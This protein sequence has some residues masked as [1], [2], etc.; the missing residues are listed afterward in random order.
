[1]FSKQNP[2]RKSIT[3]YAQM[4]ETDKLTLRYNMEAVGYWKK[5]P[6]GLSS[7]TIIIAMRSLTL[8]GSKHCQCLNSRPDS[9]LVQGHV[10][11]VVGL[12]ILSQGKTVFVLARVF[13]CRQKTR[14]SSLDWHH[15]QDLPGLC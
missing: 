15:P 5:N 7:S 3:K 14:Q 12:V 8:T 13:S 4:A 1:M 11:V 2:S 10:V 6:N 9:H